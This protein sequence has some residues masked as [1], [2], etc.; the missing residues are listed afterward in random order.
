MLETLSVDYAKSY[1]RR[2]LS[3]EKSVNLGSSN[4]TAIIHKYLIWRGVTANGRYKR[5]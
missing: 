3:R 5:R 4:I 1:I 2:V